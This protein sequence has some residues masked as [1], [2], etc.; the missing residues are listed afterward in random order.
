MRARLSSSSPRSRKAGTR[1]A[2]AARRQRGRRAAGIDRAGDPQR[3]HAV[4]GGLGAGRGAGARAADRVAAAPD[5]QDRAR[6]GGPAA[7]D[8]WTRRR[9]VER[10]PPGKL[11]RRPSA[12]L[13]RRRPQPISAS[14]VSAS[15]TGAGRGADWKPMLQAVKAAIGALKLAPASMPPPLLIEFDRFPGMAGARTISRSSACASSSCQ[16]TPRTADLV[17]VEGSG[18]GVLRDARCRCFDAAMSWWR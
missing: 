6:Q 8:R 9:G 13:V 17:P 11:H 5:L 7:I 10:R 2:S 18:L 4:P 15:W 1:S 3:R 16:A 14:A 12:S